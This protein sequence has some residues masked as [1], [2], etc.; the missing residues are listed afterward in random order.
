MKKS[1]LIVCFYSRIYVILDRAFCIFFITLGRVRGPTPTILP[2]KY[3]KLK[4]LGLSDFFPHIPLDS[5]E[6]G[7]K[8][9][10][11]LTPW[12]FQG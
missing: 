4:P 6:N 12:Y 3:H 9:G 8:H 11:E 5:G 2:S 10:V 7:G 1:I